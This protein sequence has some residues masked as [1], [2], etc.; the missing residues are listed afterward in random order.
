MIFLLDLEQIHIGDHV[1][2]DRHIIHHTSKCGVDNCMIVEYE[3]RGKIYRDVTDELEAAFF[4]QITF[5]EGPERDAYGVWVSG[6]APLIDPISGNTIALFGLDL[7]ANNWIWTIIS[8]LLY[9]IMMIVLILFLVVFGIKIAKSRHEILERSIRI[10]KQ[11]DV[12][13]KFTLSN[14]IYS[15][16]FLKTLDCLTEI[17]TDTLSIDEAS[18]WLISEDN[19]TFRCESVNY[20]KH[21]VRAENPDLTVA[22]FPELFDML[23]C[24]NL[25]SINNIKDQAIFVNFFHARMK[26]T[27]PKSLLIAN[28]WNNRQ[29]IGVVALESYHAYREWQ[30]DEESF[31]ETIS[32]IVSQVISRFQK[33]KVEKDLWESNQRFENTLESITDGFIYF[34]KELEIK[35]INRH[36]FEI[37]NLDLKLSQY[38]QIFDFLPYDL[39]KLLREMI[40]SATEKNTELYKTEFI[41]SLN[42]WLEFR[43]Y[44]TNDDVSLFF[45]DVTQKKQTEKAIYESQRLS[46]I[47]EMANAFS[48]DFNN[49]LQVILANIDVLN[50]K[51]VTI[52]DVQDYLNTIHLATKDAATRVQLLQRFAGTKS[53]VSEYDRVNLNAITMDA[54]AQS[55]PVWKTE[56]EKHGIKI[57]LIEK[58]TVI[59]DIIGNENELRAVL[60]NLIKNS[61]EAMPKGGDIIIETD[62]NHDGAF[63]RV[64]DH[65]EGIP[66]SDVHRVFEPFFTTKGF[67]AGK[68]LGL[69]GV[70]NI[71]QEH[72]GTIR[73]ASTKVGHGTTFEI[74]IPYYDFLE[75]PI[76]SDPS[77][78]REKP[79]VLWVDDD[80]MIRQIGY[81]MLSIINY[82]VTV[83][84]SGAE[85]L[86]ILSKG[87]FDILLSDIGMPGM[88]GWQL[89]DIV[90]ELYPGK[91][92]RVLIS[93]WGDQVTEEQKIE[94][95]IDFVLA[96][97]VNMKQMKKLLEDLWM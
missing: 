25:I 69:S 89:M 57:N 27:I 62:S 52:K 4:T 42:K 14:K 61:V 38:N 12:L 83:A 80:D 16:E 40:T 78:K 36:T 35:F 63:L 93:G 97:P 23:K 77:G 39:S 29:I 55:K 87:E 94:H 95:K 26:N 84:G 47:G 9:Q 43:I 20:G 76:T 10:N 51:L 86:D 54:I 7:D 3:S 37:L 71:I 19:K 5:V 41:D 59:S 88:S 18:I 67:D 32:A 15:L 85:A 79:I 72:K 28:I 2:E 82:E 45:S 50:Q 46:T 49:Y 17:L 34:N 6:I 92:K 91:Y 56:P 66:E 81:E 22:D 70:Y 21:G 8:R 60:Y 1:K 73:V 31:L 44:P 13:S 11:R 48:H 68:G 53:K 30:A 96:K 64:I 90:N 58:C 74:F 65:G 75:K 33:E 24:S